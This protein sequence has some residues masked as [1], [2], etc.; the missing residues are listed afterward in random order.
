MVKIGIFRKNRTLTPSFR[1]DC[2]TILKILTYN[3]LAF[4]M[5]VNMDSEPSRDSR[6]R[7]NNNEEFDTAAAFRQLEMLLAGGEITKEEYDDRMNELRKE[8]IRRSVQPN[9]EEIA[10]VPDDE[11]NEEEFDDS[12]GGYGGYAIDENPFGE[13][14]EYEFDQEDF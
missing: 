14:L 5:L 10:E 3:D 13:D 4:T 1:M 2:M 11:R 8:K 12:E 9:M 6:G 7:R